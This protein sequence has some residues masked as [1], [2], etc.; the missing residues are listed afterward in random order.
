MNVFSDLLLFL[1]RVFI[2]Q[3]FIIAGFSKLV[4]FHSTLSTMT[5]AGVPYAEIMLVIAIVVELGGGLLLLFGWLTRLGALML[6]VFIVLAT[7]YFHSFWDF[8]AANKINQIYHFTKNVSIVG[9]LIYVLVI[10]SG[11]FGLDYLFRK[12]Q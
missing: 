1:G 4:E 7:Y 8:E 2:S 11:R 5:T 12:K 3:I 10:G 9:G 6:I